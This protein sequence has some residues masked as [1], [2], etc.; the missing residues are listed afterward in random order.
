MDLI[1]W[2]RPC[3]NEDVITQCN[4]KIVPFSFYLRHT[5]QFQT[6]V[7]D[8]ELFYFFNSTDFCWIRGLIPRSVVFYTVSVSFL[9][10]IP[11]HRG[12]WSSVSY[13][14]KELTCARPDTG[15]HW[16]KKPH[17]ASYHMLN[18][19]SLLS[20]RLCFW[21]PLCMLSPFFPMSQSTSLSYQCVYLYICSFTFNVAKQTAYCLNCWDSDIVHCLRWYI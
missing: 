8:L 21:A 18:H 15:L 20:Q 3:S 12:S 13:S 11:W 1:Q 17:W 16:A 7:W 14:F 10:D 6:T 19:N 4:F 2:F 9:K 5:F